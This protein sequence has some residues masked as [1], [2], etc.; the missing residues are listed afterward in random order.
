[1]K[2]QVYAARKKPKQH[3][4]GAAKVY[5][6]AV[7]MPDQNLSELLFNEQK[8]ATRAKD[9]FRLTVIR[10]L[11]SELQNSAIA[12]KAP[13]DA[14]EELTILTLEVKRREESLQEFEKSGRQDLIDDL[15]EEIA[16][17]KKYLPEQLGEDELERMIREAIAEAGAET[18]REMGKVMSLIMP[19]V[20][21]RANGTLVR[22]K[23]EDVLK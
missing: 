19:R 9:R 23:V 14:D 10:M 1:M 8:E 15:K 13:L 6:G 2:N 20:K 7:N 4:K 16:M 17:L 21:G 11:R 18:K 12:K 3:V 5:R 22:K